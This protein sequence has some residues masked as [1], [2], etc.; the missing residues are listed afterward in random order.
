GALANA[1]YQANKPKGATAPADA[2]RLDLGIVKD[3][4]VLGPFAA[5]D[6]PDIEKAYFSDEATLLP[7]EGDKS[8]GQTRKLLPTSIDTQS[9]HYTNEGTCQDYNVDFVFLY[10]Q[11][12]NQVAYAHTYL[13]SPTGG[14][15][16]LS[17]HR[18]GLAGKIWFN[19]QPT[20][21]NPKDYENIHKANVT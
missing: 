2:P 10:G 11:L 5:D 4:L 1:Q 8:G 18:A 9:T 6:A 21:M 19:G 7:S 13:Y 14:P 3:W 20:T 16:Q 15:T 17:I 12:K